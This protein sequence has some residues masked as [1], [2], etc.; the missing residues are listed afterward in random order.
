MLKLLI[1]A[2]ICTTFLSACTM[3]ENAAAS[4]TQA[5]G[6]KAVSVTTNNIIDDIN[7]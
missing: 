5:V 7:N 3:T 4:G 2:I 6:N 1:A